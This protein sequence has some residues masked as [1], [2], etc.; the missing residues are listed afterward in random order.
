MNK[1]AEQ[2]KSFLEE[3]QITVFQMEE[4]EGNELH[5]VVFRSNIGVEGQQLPTMVAIDDSIFTV[6][7]VQ[8]APQALKDENAAELMKLVNGQNFKLFFDEPGNLML[9]TCL[10]AEGD[11]L[12]GDTVYQMFTVII[13]YLDENYRNIMK[14]VWH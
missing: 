11:K 6:I 9:D 4:I 10:V 2:F 3:R 14:A 8:V 7:R 1:K 12:D 13:N 5:T